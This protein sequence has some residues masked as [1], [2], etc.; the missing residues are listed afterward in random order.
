M[1]VRR[2][3]DS[4]GDPP[5][6]STFSGTELPHIPRFLLERHDAL[7]PYEPARSTVYRNSVLL[8][9]PAVASSTNTMGEVNQ[10]L[11]GYTIPARVPCPGR[12]GSP[13]SRPVPRRQW[14]PRP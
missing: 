7:Q 12:N 3:R 10:K 9:D 11:A 8:V 14:M 1:E 4:A 13:S 6:N 5:L 2:S